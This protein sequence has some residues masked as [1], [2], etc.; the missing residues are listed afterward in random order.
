MTIRALRKNPEVVF[1]GFILFWNTIV[2]YGI[3]EADIY[4]LKLG[5]RWEWS[6][7][8]WLSQA[9]NDMAKWNSLATV[10]GPQWS[11]VWMLMAGAISPYIIVKVSR[12]SI[13]PSWC[14][15]SQLSMAWV[16]ATSESG[17][18]TNELGLGSST[19]MDTKSPD[20]WSLLSP[21]PWWPWESPRD[22][23][24]ALLQNII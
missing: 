15:N 24:R 22:W 16:I 9:L 6:W 17:W 7:L 20:N 18:I 8:K 3:H 13:S 19:L 2:K 21:D 11:R 10:N 1:N 4:N 12:V 14:Q 23:L 5:F